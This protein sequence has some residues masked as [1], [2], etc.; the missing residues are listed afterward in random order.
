MASNVDVFIDDKLSSRNV[1]NVIECSRR[2]IFVIFEVFVV[3]IEVDVL[4]LLKLLVA[5]L[6]GNDLML[7]KSFVDVDAWCDVDDKRS[8]SGSYEK[9][10][11]K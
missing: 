8:W 7:G 4:R 5:W 3:E 10:F 9:I 2:G 1:D 6:I 11:S